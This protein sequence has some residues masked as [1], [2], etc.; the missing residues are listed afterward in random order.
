MDNK[1]LLL[2]AQ[3]YGTPTFV[4]D[5]MQLAALFSDKRERDA[6][7]EDIASYNEQLTRAAA[8][9]DT[10]RSNLPE[11]AEMQDVSLLKAQ[12]A[13]I[14]QKRDEAR[15]T[16]GD[17]KAE[18]ERISTKLCRIKELCSDS[19]DK[20]KRA[21]DMLTLYK[22]VAGQTGDKI[23]L[24]SYIQGQLFDRVL[25][26]ANERLI[27]M[28]GG[29]Y[30]FRRRLSN[31]NKRS[32]AGLDIDIIDNNAGSKSARD[33]S[34]LSGGERFFASFALAIGLSDFTLEQEGGRR[35]DMLFVDEG[36]S[37]LD[38][39]TFELALEVINSISAQQRTV[40]LVSHVKEI[41]QHFPDRRIYVRKGRNGSH[42]E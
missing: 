29:R 5:E 23:S 35:S 38:T 27:H 8:T 9:L 28:S 12:E 22:A 11:N 15:R 37:A 17:A 1:Q 2:A 33:V 31:T 24:E 34:T 25:D 3:T 32:T 20:A 26:K 40:G 39:N 7:A 16:S 4:F 13:E 10:C 21:A 18:A 41:Q 42:I 30:R 36:F 14:T 6:L 19:R